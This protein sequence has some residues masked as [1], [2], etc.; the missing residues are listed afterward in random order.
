MLVQ[1]S[2]TSVSLLVGPHPHSLSLAPSRSLGP[3]ALT[4][5][6]NV[7]N[8]LVAL[9]A[10]FS[11]RYERHRDDLVSIDV[12]GLGRLLGPAR[13]IGEAL[14]RE[15]AARGLHVRVALAGT[16]TAAIVLVHAR[17]GLTLVEQ[18]EEAAALAPL[19]LG[20][21]EKIATVTPEAES[22]RS[23]PRSSA[24]DSLEPL[25][26]FDRLRVDL[27]SA[28]GRSANALSDSAGGGPPSQGFGASA[29]ARV[30][31]KRAEA[32]APARV[33][34]GG[35]PR[36]VKNVGGLLASPVSTLKSWG[37]KTLGE[38]AALPPADLAA[39]LGPQGLVWQAI[40]RGE[41]VR[42]LVPDVPEERFESSI[43]LEWPIDGL[44]PLSFVLTRLLEPLST[45]LERRDR[46]A[47]VLHVM[48]GLV[49][50]DT[51][52]RSLQLP[53][54][55]RDVRT[56]RTL[57]LLDLESHPPA[58]AIDRVT[59]VIDPT[60]GRVL[61]H[62]LFTRAHPT[63]EQLSTLLARLG[64]LMGQDRIGAPALVDS[65][66]PGAFATMPFATDHESNRRA[67]RDRRDHFD[68][69]ASSAASA[70]TVVSALRRCRHPVPA[71][72]AVADG[73]PVRVTTDRRGFAGGQVLTCAGPWRTSGEGWSACGHAEAAAM[74]RCGE[75]S[76]SV[77]GG[78]GAPPPVKKWGSASIEKSR[79]GK[80]GGER[81]R[82]ERG[83]G[84][85][86]G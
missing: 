71:R 50:R 40:A 31:G 63:P 34:K 66:R 28:E 36:Q 41:D 74:E 16:R 44:E 51:Y 72:V 7:V 42:P 19:P 43:E 49:T 61:Q 67:R 10:D 48:L 20:I 11:P 45:R 79:A 32:E 76:A 26:P 30:K 9:A 21:L 22:L 46:G 8:A 23:R 69:S 65:Y 29:E 35:A 3:Q 55:M 82:P 58:A 60:P 37:L 84:G 57:A 75:A 59:L 70:L 77:R 81:L 33:N 85:K 27:S 12:S 25:R 83:A 56:L 68:H 2:A 52:T 73:H 38:L 54:P 86:R 6:L 80:A 62:T 53:S 64:A 1:N 5:A 15:A 13:A 39:R 17:P 18:G 24:R 78:G 4:S 14:R 47:A